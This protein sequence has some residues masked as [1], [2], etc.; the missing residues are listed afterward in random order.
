MYINE[1]IFIEC[2][3]NCKDTL[4]ADNLTGTKSDNQTFFKKIFRSLMNNIVPSISI[5]KKG[6]KKS[7][8]NF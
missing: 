1:L 2:Y 5:T 7:I 4:V 6:L 8:I 3:F